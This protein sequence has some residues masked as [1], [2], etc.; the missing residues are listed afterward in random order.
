MV[1]LAGLMDILLVSGVL[2]YAVYLTLGY[3]VKIITPPPLQQG[4]ACTG[5][6]QECEI[7][8]LI[9]SLQDID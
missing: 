1:E 8:T 4:S 7:R 9:P 3:L 5:C 2:A 6:E